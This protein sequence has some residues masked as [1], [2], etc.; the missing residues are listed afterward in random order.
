MSDRFSFVRDAELLGYIEAL[1]NV[2]SWMKDEASTDND[3]IDLLSAIVRAAEFLVD[4]REQAA[5]KL[6][7]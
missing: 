7:R 6:P 4:L 3:D 1:D 2:I 5:R